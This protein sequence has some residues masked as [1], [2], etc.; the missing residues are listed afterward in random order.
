MAIDVT[1][2]HAIAPVNG[3]FIAAT[4]L[5]AFVVGLM[6]WRDLRGVPDLMM[7]AV[8]FWCVHQPRRIG[9]AIPFALGLLIDTANGALM[10]QHA[11]AYSVLAFIAMA[12]NRRILWFPL[13]PQALHILFTLLFVD[14]L[15]LSV[16]MMAGAEFPGLTYF[17]GSFINAGLWPLA[18]VVLVAHQRRSVPGDEA[19]GL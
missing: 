13:W 10:G 2:G 11:L 19:R 3:R 7:L 5:V 17:L 4:F 14:L 6:P 15:T 8:A 18:T 1:Q 12:L 16:R 9:F